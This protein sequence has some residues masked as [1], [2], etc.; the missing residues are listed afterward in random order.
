MADRNLDLVLRIRAL[1]QGD[2]SIEDLRSDLGDLAEEIESAASPIDDLNE[3]LRENADASREAGAQVKE[4][5]GS[6]DDFNEGLRESADASREAG[7]QAK[8]TAG[9]FG[10]LKDTLIGLATIGL[11][12]QILELND[13]IAALRRGFGV[14]TGD[15]AKTD[16]ALRFVRETADKLGVG[17]NDL[18]KSYLKLTAAAKGTQLEG[19]A[20]EQIFSS[21]A[22]AMSV[23]GAGTQEVDQAMT[24]M[25]QIMSKGVVSAEELRGQLG[26]VLPGAAQ[27]AAESLLATNAEFNKMLESGEIIASEFLPK[28]ATQLEKA[29]GAGEGRVETFG[30]AWARLVNQLTDVATG[31]VGAGFTKFISGL[32]DALGI[33]TR[34]ATF[35][36]DAI[37]AIGRAMGGLAAGEPGAALDDLGQSAENAALKLFGIK[38]AA[39]QAAETQKQIRAELATL[40]PEMNRFQDAV[41]RQ[42][43]KDLPEYLQA[44]VS[45]LRKTGDVAAATTQA[46]STFIASI[47]KNLN[48]EGVL[49]LA[50]ALKAVGQ[51]AKGAGADIQNSLV[52]AIDH[53]SDEQLERLKQQA[54]AAMAAAV[55]GSDDARRAFAD[56]GLVIDAVSQ[57]QLKRAREEA[58]QLSAA[59]S[60][61]GSAIDRFVA[62][63]RNSLQAEIDL[64]TAR[65]DGLT[66][67]QKSIELAEKEAYWAQAGAEA[68]QKQ[69]QADI[70]ATRAKIAELE[71]LKAGSEEQAKA[72]ALQ[73]EAQKLKLGALVQEGEVAK[74]Q[75]ATAQATAEL[76]AKIQ[77]FVLAGY[78][79]IEAKKLALL[80]SGQFV[81]ALKLE[82]EQRKKVTEE[83]KQQK[84]ADQAVAESTRAAA[85]AVAKAAKD[86][87]A[88][89]QAAGNVFTSTLQG[90]E[91][92][93]SALSDAA[94]NAFL[95]K[96]GAVTSMRETVDAADQAG[97][98]LD[99]LGQTLSGGLGTGI[100]RELNA[101]AVE[102][103]EVEARFWGQVAAAERLTEQLQATADGGKVNMNALAQ[104]TRGVSGEF[105]LLDSQQL[106]QLRSAIGAANDKLREMQAEAG[107]AR[108]EI[109]RLNAEIAEE[110]GD[111]EKAALLRQQLAYEQALADIQ[112]K[113]NQAQLEGNREL[114]ALYDE[115]IRR[116]DELNSLK[117]KNIK[118]DAATARQQANDNAGT[119]TTG[120]GTSTGGS[121]TVNNTFMID[122]TA[123]TSEEWI[124]RN[125]LPTFNKVT[126]LRG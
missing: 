21:L 69:V 15:A 41:D 110:K 28:F 7:V 121:T 68:K 2:G 14:V 40:V 49:K 73:I 125:V 108:D 66:A 101:I 123:L 94:Y 11:A 105:D 87:A 120:G 44:A 23:V 104:A 50:G 116:L 99:A 84:N 63:Q 80:A 79:E 38:T 29:L 20:T 91:Q 58:D 102:A 53:L 9:A 65:G 6:T 16:E 42:A 54:T 114:V 64:A 59:Y 112:T 62:A 56:L 75:A 17:V 98:A 117:E 100:V 124:R 126:R 119:T 67:T 103:Q 118:A 26:D 33:V 45:E 22:G 36:S 122:P 93:L 78:D 43:L 95:G 90:W 37:G 86:A 51:E 61:Y 25:A 55:K 70:A 111:T 31:P 107:N 47:E 27:Q 97:A 13:Q 24:A 109:A 83:S 76:T 30:A 5:A 48:L 77:Q 115:Q 8:G 32:V 92:R 82:E 4:A 96:R 71:A 57:T 113:R 89:T 3:G 10:A 85:A 12:Q 88:Q 1:V 106:D 18:A 34:G 39:E 60:D 81:E 46:V 72:N 52:E 35:A 19:A 74:A